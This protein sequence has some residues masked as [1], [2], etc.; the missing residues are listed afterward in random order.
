[1][2]PAHS[3]TDSAPLHDTLNGML[4]IFTATTATTMAVAMSDETKGRGSWGLEELH[5]LF[6]LRNT[7]GAKSFGGGQDSNFTVVVFTILAWLIESHSSHS[8]LT[9]LGGKT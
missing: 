2:L 5:T 6:C 8:T 3:K 9:L 1:M 7:R 4:P